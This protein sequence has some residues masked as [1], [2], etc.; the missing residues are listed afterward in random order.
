MS[1][2]SEQNEARESG[3]ERGAGVGRKEEMDSLIAETNSVNSL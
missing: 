1:I 3:W 2:E